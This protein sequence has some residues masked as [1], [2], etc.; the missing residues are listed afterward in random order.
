MKNV[1]LIIV[2]LMLG[3]T[4]YSHD[5]RFKKKIELN[6]ITFSFEL[7]SNATSESLTLLTNDRYQELLV[8]VIDKSGFVR[9]QKRLHADKEIDVSF[10][11]EGFY[12]V[13]VYH[14]NNMAVQRFYKGK[15]RLNVK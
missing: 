11:R 12:L 8:K 2:V 13:K 3:H 10:L 15:D 5:F 6:E 14:K 7:Q 9:I 4:T 1:I